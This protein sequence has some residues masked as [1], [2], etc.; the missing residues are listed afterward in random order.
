MKVRLDQLLVEKEIVANR[1]KAKILIEKSLVKVDGK[2]VLKSGT[3]VNNDCH[4]EILTNTFYVSRAAYKLEKALNV[5]SVNPDGFVCADI[6]ASTGGFSEVLLNNGAKFIYAV[7]VGHDQ[8]DPKLLSDSRVENIEGFNIKNPLTLSRKVD[9]AVSDLSYISLRL[10]FHNIF[11]L[12]K[13]DGELIVLIKPQFEAGLERLGKDAVIRTE[14]VRL[15]VLEEV[16]S[17]FIENNY[18]I[19]GLDQSPIEGKQG[20]I[21]YLAYFKKDQSPKALVDLLKFQNSN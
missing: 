1:S 14:K 18:P 13:D 3:N 21:E 20:N 9:L 11:D 17:W 15:E 4:L 10:V 8:L 16:I 5:F 6:G 19:V 7:D 2:I 12:V